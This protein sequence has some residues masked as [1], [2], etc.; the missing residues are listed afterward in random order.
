MVIFL[1]VPLKITYYCVART[2]FI[3]YNDLIIISSL[4][5]GAKAHI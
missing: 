1:G 4:S 5:S 2:N 3:Q